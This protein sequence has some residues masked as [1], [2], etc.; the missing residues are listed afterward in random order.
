[1]KEV[2]RDTYFKIL[3]ILK[4]LG[5]RLRV[6]RLTNINILVV[7][8]IKIKNKSVKLEWNKNKEKSFSS[9]TCKTT[10]LIQS[11]I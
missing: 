9:A 1:L 7:K 4:D 3:N 6:D 2:R 5:G 8:M 10:F 11:Q